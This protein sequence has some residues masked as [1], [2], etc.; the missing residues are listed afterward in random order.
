MNVNLMGVQKLDFDN[1][2]GEKIQGLKLH[3][4]FKDPYV[5]GLKCDSKFIS[6]AACKNLGISESSL[7]PLIGKPVVLE[8]DLKGKVV[9]VSA[10]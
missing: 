8:T 2:K 4:A 9:G 6:E 1:D 10:G 5:S 3:I 7:T